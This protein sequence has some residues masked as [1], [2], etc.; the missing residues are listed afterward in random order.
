[1]TTSTRASRLRPDDMIG[2]AER[3]D[4]RIAAHEAD[5]GP[6]DV[7]GQAQARGDDLV[8]AG[9]DE[10]GAARDDEMGDA[11]E[12]RLRREIGDRRQRQL[13]RRLGI[14]FH[15][16]AG[17]LAARD[18]RSRPARPASRPSGVGGSTDQRRS[19]PDRSAILRNKARL[20]RI[21]DA[22]LGPI[23]ECAVHLMRR[24]GGSD[25]V[26]VGGRQVRFPRDT[27]LLRSRG[28]DEQVPGEVPSV[29][30][31]SR[32]RLSI[33]FGVERSMTVTMD[34]RACIRTCK[35]GVS[36]SS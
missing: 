27:R 29:H 25:G 6:L 21:G 5:Q 22:R 18:G 26:D 9:R 34:R 23:D 11:V 30:G 2:E 4:R 16:R 14:D 8:D 32:A 24:D 19:I 3:G 20:A 35:L 17:R 7:A 1:M 13:R 36:L 33:G 15:P 12:R 28:L 10:A 31:A